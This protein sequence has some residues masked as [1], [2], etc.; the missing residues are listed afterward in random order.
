MLLCTLHHC[1][2]FFSVLTAFIASLEYTQTSSQQ[3]QPRST[4]LGSTKWA[5]FFSMLLLRPRSTCECPFGLTHM[6]GRY[7]IVWYGQSLRSAATRVMAFYF[8]TSALPWGPWNA[9]LIQGIIP[10]HINPYCW[11]KLKIRSNVFPACWIANGMASEGPQLI[12]W[13]CWQLW[14]C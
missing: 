8:P 6:F 11:H 1:S 9:L 3:K 4:L 12:C 14:R 7:H 2:A 13:A 5:N 10:W